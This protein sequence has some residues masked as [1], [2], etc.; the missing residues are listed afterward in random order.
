MKGRTIIILLA[1]FSL[2][3]STL[4]FAKDY[5]VIVH[6]SNPI[7]SITAND[8]KKIFLGEKTTWPD[9]QQIKMA[10]FK[11][12]DIHKA[13]LQDIVKISPLRFAN[14]WK[15][16]IFT[17]SGTGTHINFFTTE[18]KVKEYV[19]SNPTAIGYISGSSVDDTIKKIKITARRPSE[20][21]KKGSNVEKGRIQNL[22]RA[23][24]KASGIH[25]GVNLVF[26]LHSR[27]TS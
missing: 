8:L 22:D 9:G 23:P 11:T 26:T 13:F 18:K 19:K 14:H 15:Q 4:N 25:V 16:K 10:V 7:Q 17:G 5:A 3:A 20:N 21:A 1:L 2:C 6:P 24:T 27:T 12:G